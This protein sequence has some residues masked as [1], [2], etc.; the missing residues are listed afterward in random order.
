MIP[1]ELR[2]LCDQLVELGCR[3]DR[4]G[5]QFHVYDPDGVWLTVFS[6]VPRNLQGARQSLT[7]KLRRLVKRAVTP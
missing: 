3:I 4:R 7:S 2:P 1:H 5:S 6:G